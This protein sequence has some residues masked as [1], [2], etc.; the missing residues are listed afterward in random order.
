L[1]LAIAIT[2]AWTGIGRAKAQDWQPEPMTM[3]VPVAADSSSDAGGRIL[4]QRL[5]ELLH[6]PVIVENAG[7]AGG[8][9]SGDEVV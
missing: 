5:P 8:Q 7:G 4:S 9:K 6:Q 3:L 1:L 2:A